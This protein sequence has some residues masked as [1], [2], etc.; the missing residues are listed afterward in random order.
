MKNQ[1]FGD[2]KDYYK[3]GLL[4]WLSQGGKISTSVCWMLTKPENNKQG[5]DVGYLSNIAQF[6]ACDEDLFNYLSCVVPVALKLDIYNESDSDKRF[7]MIN[8]L[9]N[10]CNVEKIE[11]SGR[12]LNTKFNSLDLDFP[13]KDWFYLEDRNRFESGRYF[14]QFEK[15][16][17][18]SD[19]VFFDPDNGLEVKTMKE[20]SKYLFFDEITHFYPRCSILIFQYSYHNLLNGI[21][22]Q[23]II[24]NLNQ[25][26]SKFNVT[27]L[28]LFKSPHVL[29]VLM[30]NNNDLI[31]RAQEFV[32]SEWHIR[33]LLVMEVF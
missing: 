18:N 30:T 21:P 9:I 31:D 17:Q 22:D 13:S 32:G 7:D 28:Y 26:K 14:Q 3:Y 12:L 15:I 25:L 1:Y 29:F 33:N 16:S 4:R 10:N 24:D 5:M 23:S 2:V 6:R 20:Y 8:V 11:K 27:T 19:L